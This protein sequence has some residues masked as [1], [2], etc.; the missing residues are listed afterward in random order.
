[1]MMNGGQGQQI[2]MMLRQAGDSRREDVNKYQPAQTACHEE[3]FISDDDGSEEDHSENDKVSED[4][5]NDGSEEDGSSD[6]DDGDEVGTSVH[7]GREVEIDG[8]KDKEYVEEGK[9]DD[10]DDEGDD[11]KEE[12]ED[13]EG[14][15]NDE[16]KEDDEDAKHEVKSISEVV[17]A[18]SQENLFHLSDVEDRFQKFMSL[19]GKTTNALEVNVLDV[20]E[21]LASAMVIEYGGYFVTVRE[22]AKSMKK[23][24]FVL[25][26]VM[27][28]GIQSIMFNL[29]PDSKKVLMPL[30]F[31]IWLQKMELTSKELIS[32][33]KKSN[34]LDR[35]D[36]SC[37][38]LVLDAYQADRSPGFRASPSLRL[39]E[40]EPVSAATG[41]MGS[42][43]GKLGA[44][45]ADGHEV[46]N[47]DVESLK[48][49][50]QAVHA[51]LKATSQA[52]DPGER[53]RRWMKE[54][55]ELS[56]DVEDALDK[57]MLHSRD[58]SGAADNDSDGFSEKMSAWLS[59]A[60]ARRRTGQE[61]SEAISRAC[62]AEAEDPRRDRSSTESR[63][64]PWASTGPPLKS[65]E[66]WTEEGSNWIWS[67]SNFLQDKRYFI[68]VDD[69]WDVQTWDTLKGA[70]PKGNFGSRIITTTRI[71]EVAKS[72]CASCGG[73]VY[74]CIP[75]RLCCQEG[76][77]EIGGLFHLKY[78]RLKSKVGKLPQQ[79]AEL[80]SL[81]SLEICESNATT[82]I[83]PA[84]NQLTRLRLAVLMWEVGEEDV[85]ILGSLP[86][87]RHLS[88]TA[89]A[90]GSKEGRL[91]VA[92][93]HG[94]PS[95]ISFQI[96]GE[97]CAL[98]LVF[99]AGSM[100][101]LQNLE[102]EFDAEETSSV[103]DGRH[104][105]MHQG[106]SQ[107]S[108]VDMDEMNIWKK[109]SR[110]IEPAVRMSKKM[111]E[112]DL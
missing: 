73:R 64:S 10:D 52:E 86:D 25:S 90:A 53:G 92:Q 108:H 101:K 89:L 12:K 87:L 71:H 61:I 54:A 45:F 27:E 2:L 19:S 88:L 97:E 42:V 5:D 36:M 102:L 82:E 17:Q 43:L 32:R 68:M 79:I 3:S 22:L 34:H 7:M 21:L 67:I 78:L 47:G 14:D 59:E 20:S 44:L 60:A 107:P 70:F 49:E 16:E 4:K 99:E 23:E 9:E 35:Q 80:Q 55:R 110:L 85:V 46:S 39:A 28:V 77:S 37:Q 95:L 94:F 83:P 74:T 30:R 81:E 51:F 48:A 75:G 1:M 91:R 106:P 65:S 18:S 96:G 8:N 112:H 38:S 98:G 111:G 6:N 33:F 50:L 41:A 76:T 84:I 40:M 13:D 31:S 11:N 105:E 109:S 15:D 24:G 103:T 72:C 29:P 100:P 26:H 57:F 58:G 56:Y 66:W 63:V 69:V 104:G 93:S 62:G